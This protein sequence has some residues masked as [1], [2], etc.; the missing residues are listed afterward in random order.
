MGE[1]REGP[2]GTLGGEG[3]LDGTG[4]TLGYGRLFECIGFVL[5]AAMFAAEVSGF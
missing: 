1:G 3:E 5:I 2:G 4:W